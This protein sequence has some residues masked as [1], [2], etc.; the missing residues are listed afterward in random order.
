MLYHSQ[1]RGELKI[2][3]KVIWIS[4]IY[5]IVRHRGWSLAVTEPQ[6]YPQCD[7][8]VLLHSCNPNA[9]EVRQE[10]PEFKAI[11]HYVAVLKPAWS[12]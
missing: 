12:T 6:F 2:L 8:G 11:L 3:L 7:L 10:V 4:C 9:C 1:N 5:S